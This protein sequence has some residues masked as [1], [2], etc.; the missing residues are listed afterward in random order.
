MIRRRLCSYTAMYIAG[1]AAGYFLFEMTRA[2]E[3]AGFMA[4]CAF[5]AAFADIRISGLHCRAGGAEA[6]RAS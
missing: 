1:I 3:A 5:A 2:I 4:A 6:G